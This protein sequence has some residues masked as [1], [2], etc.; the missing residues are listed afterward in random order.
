MAA[1]DQCKFELMTRDLGSE[2]YILD[3]SIKTYS[4]CW[5]IHPTLDAI[6]SIVKQHD[7]GHQDIVQIDVWSVTYLCE[8]FN[9]IEP[10]EL[11]DAQFSLPYC[12]ALTLLDIKTGPGWFDKELFNNSEIL[13]IG[14]RVKIHPDSN[15]DEIFHNEKLR[16][17]AR[18]VITTTSGD[19]FEASAAA[20]RGSPSFP[21]SEDEIVVKYF[22]LATPVIGSERAQ[23][24]KQ[25]LLDLDSQEQA[26]NLTALISV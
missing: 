21:I 25:L 19:E 26:S 15:C 20:P 1:S 17:S 13:S 18:V 24:L 16:I 9:I 8:M 5:F 22:A 11:V 6:K 23:E 3:A 2:F 12:V 10:E 4:C 7:L 14:S